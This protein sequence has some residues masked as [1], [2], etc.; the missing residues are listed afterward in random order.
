MGMKCGAITRASERGPL[1]PG[2][3]R[4]ASR[5]PGNLDPARPIPASF[6]VHFYVKLGVITEFDIGYC[7]IRRMPL[8]LMITR[9]WNNW[10][11]DRM[12]FQLT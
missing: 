12:P 1:A 5:R 10:V 3:N 7:S 11:S 8:R 4:I 9:A 2:Q 6:C